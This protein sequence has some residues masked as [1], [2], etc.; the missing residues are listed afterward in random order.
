[1]T[2]KQP[3]GYHG[4]CLCG[5]I[6]YEARGEPEMAL[7]CYC[8]QCQRT[9]G[10]GHAPQIVFAKKAVFIT[11]ELKLY[12]TKADSGSAVTNGFC[13]RCGS[14]ILKETSGYPDI[15]CLFAASL[16]DPST[17]RPS[18][19]YWSASKQPWDYLDPMLEVC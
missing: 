19:V 3:K 17:F 12:D 11:G 6:R 5:A 2:A 7:H 8:R 15:V 1:M 4:G 18:V 16:D 10:S 14:P 13:P 9:T